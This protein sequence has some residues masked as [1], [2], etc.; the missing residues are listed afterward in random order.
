MG[1]RCAVMLCE[2]HAILLRQLSVLSPWQRTA[3]ALGRRWRR[4]KNEKKTCLRYITR[5]YEKNEL[6]QIPGEGYSIY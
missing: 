6:C 1:T 2:T 4:K 5:E 3:L